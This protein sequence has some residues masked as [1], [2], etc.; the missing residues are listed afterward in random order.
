MANRTTA[1]TISKVRSKLTAYLEDV[2]TKNTEVHIVLPSGKNAVLIS[3]DELNSLRIQLREL[4]DEMSK[5]ERLQ[6]IADPE[7]QKYETVE[8]MHKDILGDLYDEL[9]D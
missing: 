3:E 6:Y 5:Q 9:P 8:K 4:E 1:T 2:T 7:T